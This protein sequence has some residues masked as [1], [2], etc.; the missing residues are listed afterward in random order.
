MNS[1]TVYDEEEEFRKAIERSKAENE[2]KGAASRK[3]KR[4]R[5]DSD[6]YVRPFISS[7]RG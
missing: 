7:I 5:T 1:R 6:E 3:T 2:T 4:S